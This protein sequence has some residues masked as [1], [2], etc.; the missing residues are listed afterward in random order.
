MIKRAEIQ[1]AYPLGQGG[2]L[3][4]LCTCTPFVLYWKSQLCKAENGINGFR[5]L[6]SLLRKH[7]P[8]QYAAILKAVKN[9]ILTC[10]CN[11]HP[12]TSRFYVVNMGFTGLYFS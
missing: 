1:R 12:L 11:V 10:P 9:L 2:A 4:L 5:K 3:G 8:M 6:F 7:M